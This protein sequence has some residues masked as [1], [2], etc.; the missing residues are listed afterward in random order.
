MSFSTF[1]EIVQAYALMAETYENSDIWFTLSM[2]MKYN[3]D[4]GNAY[5]RWKMCEMY[6]NKFV[7]MCLFGTR[8]SVIDALMDVADIYPSEEE[9]AI[10][11][12]KSYVQ[13]LHDEMFARINE[14]RKRDGLKEMKTN[15]KAK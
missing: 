7:A 10:Q 2:E 5:A 11:E 15:G 9:K 1:R 8:Q 3:H 12:G 14:E 4:E 13:K 6:K